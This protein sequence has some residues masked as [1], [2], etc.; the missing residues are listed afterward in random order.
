MS[1]NNLAKDRDKYID[2]LRAL[3]LILIILVHCS[4]PPYDVL[5]SA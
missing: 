2:F 1:Q 3:G 4:P 5:M